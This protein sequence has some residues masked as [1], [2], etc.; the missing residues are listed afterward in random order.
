MPGDEWRIA[1]YALD[2]SKEFH[3]NPVRHFEVHPD[4]IM[5]R[6][7]PYGTHHITTWAGIIASVAKTDKAKAADLLSSIGE[8]PGSLKLGQLAGR[9]KQTHGELRPGREVEGA[10]PVPSGSWAA[11]HIAATGEHVITG[12]VLAWDD[13]V[14]YVGNVQFVRGVHSAVEVSAPKRGRT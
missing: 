10:C 7:T 13:T 12:Q 5:F 4:A 3:G 8:L 11:M 2:Y 9:M 1:L 6:I 14:V